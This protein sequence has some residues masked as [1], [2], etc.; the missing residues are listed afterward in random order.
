MKRTLSQLKTSRHEGRYESPAFFSIPLEF[1]TTEQSAKLYDD[2]TWKEEC[3]TYRPLVL[4]TRNNMIA[5]IFAE[6]GL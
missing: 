2:S 1:V 4:K 3:S 6:F 5:I